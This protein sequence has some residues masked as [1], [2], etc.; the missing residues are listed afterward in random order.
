MKT[1]RSSDKS[2]ALE[3][4]RMIAKIKKNFRNRFFNFL[5]RETSSDERVKCFGRDPLK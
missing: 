1:S 4:P 2:G 5:L 3:I